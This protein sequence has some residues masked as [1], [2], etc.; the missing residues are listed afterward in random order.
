[1]AA[2]AML[3]PDAAWSIASTLMLLPLYVNFQHEPHEALF[4]PATAWAPPTL[5]K[6]GS[7]PKVLKPLVSSPFE[8]SEHATVERLPALLSYV[9]SYETVM[10]EAEARGEEVDEDEEADDQD[11]EMDDVGSPIFRIRGCR[12]HRLVGNWKSR[13]V[14]YTGY[15]INI[16]SF[17]LR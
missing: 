3:N 13:F 14:R 11:E 10:A 15:G 16:G 17:E 4:Q 6:W 9:S 5:G 7:E 8:P 1:M 12:A 2:L